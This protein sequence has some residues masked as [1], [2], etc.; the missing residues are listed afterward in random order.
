MILTLIDF[1]VITRFCCTR[2]LM[3][4]S[5]DLVTDEDSI[6]TLLGLSLQLE[7]CGSMY[8]SYLMDHYFHAIEIV[9]YFHSL[10]EGVANHNNISGLH[11][12][13]K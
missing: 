2:M 11:D 4:F 6:K 13:S 9:P 5:F 12:F 10:I 1:T 3:K 7:K 8:I